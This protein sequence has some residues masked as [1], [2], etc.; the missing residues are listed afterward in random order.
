MISHPSRRALSSRPIPHANEQFG[1]V[2]SGRVRPASTP[3]PAPTCTTATLGP[4]E[5]IHFPSNFP[6]SAEALEETL[7]LDV[8][9]PPS[10]TTGIDIPRP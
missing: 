2:L 5:V 10:A 3:N 6:H 4:G 8:F 9:S 7:I 1:I